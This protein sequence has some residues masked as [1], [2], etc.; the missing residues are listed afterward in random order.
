L[1]SDLW[2]VAN[3]ASQARTGT[4]GRV[5][6]QEWRVVLQVVILEVVVG[7]KVPPATKGFKITR[8]DLRRVWGEISCTTASP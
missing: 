8:G 6:E 3:D 5:D 7:F 2:K 1:I 4:F